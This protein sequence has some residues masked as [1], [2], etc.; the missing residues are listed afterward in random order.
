[1]IINENKSN[2]IDYVDQHR[3]RVKRAWETYLKPIIRDQEVKDVVDQLIQ[4]HDL[5]KYDNLLIR[6]NHYHPVNTKF[7]SVEI[8]NDDKF[9]IVSAEHKTSNKHHP[10][11]WNGEDMPLVYILEMLSDWSSFQFKKNATSNAHIWY[12][13]HKDEIPLSKATREDVEYY[14][15]KVPAL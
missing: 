8:P 2:Y 9:E 5:D 10:E 6:S 12:E 7:L 11:Y 4:I 3:N 13:S 14:L 15:D 1:M